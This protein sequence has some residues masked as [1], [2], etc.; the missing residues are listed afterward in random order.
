MLLSQTIAHCFCELADLAELIATVRAKKKMFFD[1][2]GIPVVET[3]EGVEF[4][5]CFVGVGH[6]T[7]HFTMS[8]I[9]RKK[10]SVQ[11]EGILSR[12]NTDRAA[13]QTRSS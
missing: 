8:A 5:G 10:F 13:P 9:W 6:L 11:M 7:L 4:E 3:S 12:K 2:R 1:R